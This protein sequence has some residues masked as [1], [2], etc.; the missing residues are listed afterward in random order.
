MDWWQGL[1]SA[2]GKP[3]ADDV[4]SSSEV[5]LRW[6]PPQGGLPIT[7]YRVWMRNLLA[8]SASYAVVMSSEGQE[9]RAQIPLLLGGIYAFRV[10]AMNGLSSGEMSIPS[11]PVFALQ[12]G[13]NASNA[14]N[15]SE[16]GDSFCRAPS[17]LTAAFAEDF[18]TPRLSWR[19]PTCWPI[20]GYRLWLQRGGFGAFTLW[21]SS[22]PGGATEA[23]SAAGL[24]ATRELLVF[25]LQA[26]GMAGGGLI[27]EA[28]S[29]LT[30]WSQSNSTAPRLRPG[31]PQLGA[32][33][34]RMHL[35]LSWAGVEGASDYRVLRREGLWEGTEGF[36]PDSTTAGALTAVSLSLQS[37]GRYEFAVQALWPDGVW[38]LPSD[39]SFPF[40]P[41]TVFD[42]SCSLACGCSSACGGPCLADGL[43]LAS[44]TAGV[45]AQC[46]H[47]SDGCSAGLVLDLPLALCLPSCPSTRPFQ[48]VTGEAVVTCTEACPRGKLADA[49]RCVTQ[50]SDPEAILVLYA[51]RDFL[52]CAP[53][54]GS[55]PHVELT[56]D[57]NFTNPP[58][59]L[60][61][62][63]LRGIAAAVREPLHRF[64]L[65]SMRAGS[66][67]MDL[68]VL[69]LGIE[70]PEVPEEVARRLAEHVASR[71]RELI[72]QDTIFEALIR[73]RSLILQEGCVGENCAGGS[74]K[75]CAGENCTLAAEGPPLP[76][77]PVDTE[78]A[79]LVGASA[80]PL[81]LAGFGA[82][83]WWKQHRGQNRV[84]KLEWDSSDC[85]SP[86][87]MRAYAPSVCDED[88]AHEVDQLRATASGNERRRPKA[89]GEL[90]ASLGE[91]DGQASIDVLP[92]PAS[93]SL[94]QR[95]TPISPPLP[96][97]PNAWVNM[98]TLPPPNLDE[99]GPADQVPHCRPASG[100]TSEE[101]AAL[102][103]GP[104]SGATSVELD[105]SRALGTDE[106]VPPPAPPEISPGTSPCSLVRATPPPARPEMPP[107]PLE[108][109]SVASP[110][111][112]A[113]PP[114]GTP[115]PRPEDG[116]VATAWKGAPPQPG[117]PLSQS[118][119]ESSGL[120]LKAAPPEEPTED[121][122]MAQA[123]SAS[124]RP[125][126]EGSV[127]GALT[128]AA[129]AGQTLMKVIDQPAKEGG[130]SEALT[131][132]SLDGPEAA[133]DMVGI[134]HKEGDACVGQD[135]TLMPV[136]SADVLT[137]RCNIEQEYALTA[138]S[139]EDQVR[140][141]SAAPYG[142]L[143][144]TAL[145]PGGFLQ[146]LDGAERDLSDVLLHD[147]DK[148]GMG[149]DRAAP[150]L[151]GMA[152]AETEAE[153]RGSEGS[154]VAV[155]EELLEAELCTAP[156]DAQ[157][158]ESEPAPP[159]SCRS[160]WSELPEDDEELL[161]MLALDGDIEGS[162]HEVAAPPARG[163]A[164][165]V[166]EPWTPRTARGEG[167]EVT[168]SAA[169]SPARSAEDSDEE[170]LLAELAIE[171]VATPP[172]R[173]HRPWAL[174][175]WTPRGA[176]PRAHC[177]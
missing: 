137:E 24:D 78:P 169:T 41:S 158:E 157:E 149:C 153:G 136:P 135:E 148:P 61:V 42:R 79:A 62:R 163:H 26:V 100:A 46:V 96:A 93:T 82:W 130:V 115:L 56:F 155:L 124:Q 120:P 75:S 45:P 15:A 111:K 174:D 90:R 154:A 91:R 173:G 101:L 1:L 95:G 66:I 31:R 25:R 7:G 16:D 72:A 20:L 112:G 40:T 92:S 39:V 53:Q 106:N 3:V 118:A 89:L 36:E 145:P 74:L 161:R 134:E 144:A 81:T 164:P 83:W 165:W 68:V 170:D 73:L 131:M 110:L 156:Q 142:T 98:G 54:N 171:E 43:A 28:T 38:G 44:A 121:T 102:E 64:G 160:Q 107:P 113:P 37:D 88:D 4:I 65:V 49:G 48:D 35:V 97:W 23:W 139:F 166:L 108:G 33:I 67:I 29:P 32:L 152:W 103:E 128:M 146:E 57:L 58:P 17:L 9:P 22:I 138:T 87:K 172:P 129:I 150:P 114:P 19:A 60:A 94:A 119:E 5:V 105:S 151:R 34:S 175:S 116:N 109:G 77:Q 177:A 123:K 52:T 13:A 47:A 132:T 63:V 59:D 21:S 11:E 2:P 71:S 12:G 99:P 122:S 84:Q 140:P 14:L 69:R 159:D 104:R 51:G 8:G 76:P 125:S 80:L 141:E 10:Q 167:I 127:G 50:C 176:P 162:L 55:N 117:A 85:P 168:P 133:R 27:S 18:A 147:S 143:D 6:S 70:P 30:H 126:S 86:A